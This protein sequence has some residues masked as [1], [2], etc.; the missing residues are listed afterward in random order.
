MRAPRLTGAGGW[1]RVAAGGGGCLRVAEYGRT[2]TYGAK[3]TSGGHSTD[4]VMRKTWE[5]IRPHGL[6]RSP[7][8]RRGRRRGR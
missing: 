2:A 6:P 5:A 8:R 4:A 1:Q 3:A 7:D